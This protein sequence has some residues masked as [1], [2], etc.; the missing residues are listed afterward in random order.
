VFIV[1][2]RDRDVASARIEGWREMETVFCIM[3]VVC[4]VT[5]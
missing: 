5:S 4:I 1:E 2:G 3:A